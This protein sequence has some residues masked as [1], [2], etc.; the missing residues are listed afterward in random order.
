VGACCIFDSFLAY[1]DVL[2]G[3]LQG[4]KAS[5]LVTWGKQDD[6]IPMSVASN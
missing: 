3:K 5:V 2:D 6:L 4:V 1:Q